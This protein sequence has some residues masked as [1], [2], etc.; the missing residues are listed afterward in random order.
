MTA[1]R[2]ALAANEKK[3]IL[4][5]SADHR[6]EKILA[7]FYIFSISPPMTQPGKIFLFAAK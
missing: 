6:K 2:G 1:K 3:T 7:A 5:A 4:P